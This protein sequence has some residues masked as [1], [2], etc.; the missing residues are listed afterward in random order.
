[1]PWAWLAGC[2]ALGGWLGR[3]PGGLGWG[4]AIACLGVWLAHQRSWPDARLWA[5]GLGALLVLSIVRNQLRAPDLGEAPL[6]GRAWPV[7]EAEDWAQVQ[8]EGQPTPVRVPPGWVRPGDT[9]A[10]HPSAR[11][12][13]FAAAPGEDALPYSWVADAAQLRRHPGR[14]LPEPWPWRGWVTELRAK[15]AA[16]LVRVAEPGYEGLPQALLLGQVEAV[17]N[18]LKQTFTRT[19]TRHLLALS[20]LH[21]GW[22]WLLWIRPTTALL[23]RLLPFA[24]GL[25]RRIRGWLGLLLL[26]GMV[27]LLG[28]GTPALRAA[29]ALGVAGLARIMPA[30]PGHP[31]GSG[32]RVDGLSL[33]SFALVCECLV[34]PAAPWNLSLQLSY[35]ATLA[36]LLA[37]PLGQAWLATNGDAEDFALLGEG[38][39]R[40]GRSR[41]ALHQA[42]GAWLGRLLL[43][44]ALASL[45]ASTATLPWVWSAFGEWCPH[46]FWITLMLMPWVVMAIFVGGLFTIFPG[47]IPV[48]LVRWPFRA[49]VGCLQVV[50]R[51][52][53]T[54]CLLPERPGWAVGLAFGLAWLALRGKTPQRWLALRAALALAAWLVVPWRLPPR[55][56]EISVCDV[57]HGTAVVARMP[58]GRTWLFDGGSRDRR[59]VA[60]RLLVPYL[61]HLETGRLSVAV[62]H[63]D[64]DHAGALTYVAGRV[65]VGLW[66]GALPE[67]F[68]PGLLSQGQPMD[69]AAGSLLAPPCRLGRCS[70]QL[71]RGSDQA[72]NEGS[73]NL[74]LVCDG[75]SVLLCGDAEGEALLACIRACTPFA[76]L[77]AVLVPHH[78]SEQPF[79]TH[80][81]RTLRPKEIWFSASSHSPLAQ[82]WRHPAPRARWTDREGGWVASFWEPF[83]ALT[84]TMGNLGSAG[85]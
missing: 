13:R 47:W 66:L 24:P 70:A 3:V 6:Q 9:L 53:G 12:T 68:P 59:G 7:W 54:P 33:W 48:E 46:G 39:D 8:L 84:K 31:G 55:V 23:V 72:G 10:V 76:P 19:G 49:M 65:P 64:S 34:E 44:G 37:L 18:E 50:D 71:L 27:P 75:H 74:L 35:V 79:W 4:L 67:D 42:S 16:R 52:P 11:L 45:V 82:G 32:R 29:W 57:G 26:V 73:R 25:R 81:L 22:M 58:C 28:D 61:R 5:C 85:P 51:L 2:L 17:S 62:S 83:P 69:L 20:G 40:M 14:R 1:R 43:G 36:L 56:M 38:R 41:S 60:D 63:Q 80:L 77:D 21:V 78:G 30:H 15:L